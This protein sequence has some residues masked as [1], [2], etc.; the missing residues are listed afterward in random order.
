MDGWIWRLGW[1][2]FGYIWC[3]GMDELV[4]MIVRDYIINPDT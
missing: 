2:L 3:L 1:V 4:L